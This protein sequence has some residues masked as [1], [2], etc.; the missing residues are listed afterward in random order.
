M[1]K[2]S[3]M[4]IPLLKCLVE[5]GGSGRPLE[6]YG[7]LRKYFP[8]LTDA[9]FAETL[10]V[11]GA[12]KWRNRVRFVRQTL[13]AKGEVSSPQYG[14][15]KITERG[16]ARLAAEGVTTVAVTAPSAAVVQVGSPD[17]EEIADSYFEKFK[18]KVIQELLDLKPPQFERFAGALLPNYGFSNIKVTGKSQDGGIDGSGE[19]KVGLATMKV[20]F[21]CKR[22]Q[23]PVPRP[24]ID[25]F[26]GAIQGEF[27]QGLFFTTSDFSEPAREASVKKGATTIVLLNG[28]EIVKLMMRT[29]LGIQ[30]RPVELYEDQI[31]SLFEEEE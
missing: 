5:M 23:G 22:W 17:L 15:W 7:H 30:R 20:A 11:S 6:I 9:D 18:E 29:G 16:Y 19:L 27:E 1:P 24:D 12:N 26:R 10:T 3:E 13:I 14:I 21:Q 2:Q 25:K 4:E 28:E 31:E 8:Q